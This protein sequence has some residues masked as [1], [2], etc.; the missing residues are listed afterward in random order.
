M[1]S[2][3]IFRKGHADGKNWFIKN[4]KENLNCL[5]D[6]NKEKSIYRFWESFFEV[7][8]CLRKTML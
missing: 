1:V 3:N 5:S 7:K 6:A 2:C 4:Y 8:S